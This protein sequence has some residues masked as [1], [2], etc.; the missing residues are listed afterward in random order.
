MEKKV[1]LEIN[2]KSVRVM[3]NQVA[4]MIKHFGANK[5][6]RIMKE[7]PKELLMPITKPPAEVNVAPPVIAP[8]AETE[9]VKGSTVE[10]LKPVRKTPVRS[11]S[12]K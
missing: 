7:T 12:K 9:F 5:T 1:V 6:K 2:G 11:K 4:D 10:E 8:Q 3:E